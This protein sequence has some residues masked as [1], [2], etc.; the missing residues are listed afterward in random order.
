VTFHPGSKLSF[1]PV[2]FLYC[3]R[4]PLSSTLIIFAPAIANALP[5]FGL[6]AGLRN[7]PPPIVFSG[8]SFIIPVFDAELS[9]PFLAPL[10][11]PLAGL[12]RFGIL[13]ADRQINSP[14]F[15]SLVLLLTGLSNP[16]FVWPRYQPVPDPDISVALKRTTTS[17][18]FLNRLKWIAPPLLL[19]DIFL[20]KSL[21]PL[22]LFISFFIR[23][24][25][26]VPFW[27]N[28]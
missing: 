28:F 4:I 7:P 11:A 26:A 17:S 22:S 23:C 20:P 5:T 12:P 18:S 10:N 6:L 27:L 15:A 9:P 1:P 13:F 16:P 8:H 3:A 14:K 19:S 24:F 21:I 2:S 25:V